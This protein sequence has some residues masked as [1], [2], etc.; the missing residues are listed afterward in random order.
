MMDNPIRILI[1][2]DNAQVRY[3][4]SVF[5][6]VY[7]DFELV[8]QANNGREAVDLCHKLH[9]HLV[10]MDLQMPHMNGVE[11]TQKIRQC[12]PQIKI[13]VLT[14]SIDYDLINQAMDAGAHSYLLK[15]VN[16]DTLAEAI[17][18]AVL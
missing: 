17:Q 6:D 8:G 3:G 16:I 11:A 2:D 18:S 15:N 9:P 1:A 4:L 5:I 13:V 14:S 10:L 7:D 12:C